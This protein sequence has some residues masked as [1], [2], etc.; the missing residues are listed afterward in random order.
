MMFQ[1]VPE[2]PITKEGDLY[3]LGN[4]RLRCGDSTNIQHVEKLMDGN[5][6]DMVL[7]ILLMELNIK[8]T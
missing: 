8:D 6:A 4:H 5:K 2:E 3:I 7:P 1:K